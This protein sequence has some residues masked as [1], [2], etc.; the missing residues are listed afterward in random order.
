MDNFQY[1]CGVKKRWMIWHFAHLPENFRSQHISLI[2]QDGTDPS[3]TWMSH[4]S[5]LS[6][7]YICTLSK[8]VSNVLI[9]V[10]F[11]FSTSF[12]CSS[13]SIHGKSWNK[14]KKFREQITTP[15]FLY[16]LQAILHNHPYYH[17]C[18]NKHSL[19]RWSS[20]GKWVWF[21]ESN[22]NLV[23]SFCLFTSFILDTKK[24]RAV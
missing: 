23:I 15:V 14:I 2:S 20:L 16:V 10:M 3:V 12:S 21:T 9:G 8:P 22:I 6:S 19:G 13:V 1:N 7:T 24:R 4:F 11:A 17:F 5:S 18:P